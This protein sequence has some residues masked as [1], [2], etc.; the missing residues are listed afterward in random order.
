MI[1][2]ERCTT[3][4]EVRAG[5]DALDQEIVSLLARRF[6]F[7]EAAARV[8][9]SRGEVRDERRKAEVI[10]RVRAHARN[11]GIPDDL[12]GRFYDDLIESSIAI[13]LERFD[14]RK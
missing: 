6:Q 4:A 9:Q 13:E 2:P 1:D 5:I 11:A 10:E 14:T 3:M 12:I 7:I 8:K